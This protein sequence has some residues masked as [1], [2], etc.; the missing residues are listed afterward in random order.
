MPTPSPATSVRPLPP[1]PAASLSGSPPR[2]EPAG[3][4][5]A[6]D[7]PSAS[8]T[9]DQT[10]IYKEDDVDVAPRRLSG[11]GAAY[12]DW[13]PDLKPR[14]RVSITA[15]FVVTVNG[16]VTDIRVERGR[17]PLEVVL[18]AMSRWKY[19]PAMK[20]G[21]PVNVR[22]RYRQTFVGG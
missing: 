21:V 16:D 18:L 17:G 9:V 22:I 2:T 11:K 4:G 10:R 13:G 12:P 8:P 15:S 20:A 7:A 5:A 1:P 19:A 3:G 6:P 14:Q